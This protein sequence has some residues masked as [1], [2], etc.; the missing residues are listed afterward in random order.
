MTAVA[1]GKFDALHR[2][3]RALAGAAVR[4]ARPA[5]LLTFTGMAE[6]LGWPLR[7]PLVAPSDRTRISGEWAQELGVPLDWL[8]LPF[9]DIRH[10]DPGAFL[11]LLKERCGVTAVAVGEDFRFGRERGGDVAVLRRLAS[12]LGIEV[13]VVAHVEHAGVAVSSSR[14]R[15]LLEAGDC[16]AVTAQLGRP[17]RLVGTVAR[18][19]GRGRALGFPTA[20]CAACENLIPM[21]GVYACWAEVAGAR[22]RAA[23]NIGRLPTIAADRPLTVE[24]HLIGYHGDCYDQRLSLDVV[25]RLR[26]EQRFASLDALKAQ[27]AVDVAA[28]G[29]ALG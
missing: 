22:H 14:I 17:H 27:L 13:A 7:P 23:V 15:Q 20:N 24:A 21:P 8:E 25:A 18:G 26:D 10:L 12:V 6:V 28:A 9:A 5:A 1:I 29:A 3:H 2:G 16:A 11:A 4:M 19:D